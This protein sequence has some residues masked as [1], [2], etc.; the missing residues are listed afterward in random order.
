[1]IPPRSTR[2]GFSVTPATSFQH[3]F[4]LIPRQQLLTNLASSQPDMEIIMFNN[5]S[6]TT[7]HDIASK[8][9]HSPLLNRHEALTLFLHLQR[10]GYEPY[11]TEDYAGQYRVSHDKY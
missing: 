2:E 7:H 10:Q 3:H 1:M 8:A 4:S 6:T 5:P 9:A 11:M